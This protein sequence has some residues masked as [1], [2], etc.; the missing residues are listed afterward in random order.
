MTQLLP[1]HLEAG[2]FTF[3]GRDSSEKFKIMSVSVGSAK[4]AVASRGTNEAMVA[5]LT[6]RLSWI[7]QSPSRPTNV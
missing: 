4:F 2:E 3:E 6:W 7:A 5:E 1:G